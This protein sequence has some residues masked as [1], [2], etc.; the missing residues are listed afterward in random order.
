ML[1]RV[2]RDKNSSLGFRPRRS[3]V[4]GYIWK[5]VK[6]DEPVVFDL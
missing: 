4:S 1:R 5:Q 3:R 2:H 6:R